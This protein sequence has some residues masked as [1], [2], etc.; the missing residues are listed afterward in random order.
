MKDFEKF[1]TDLPKPAVEV[2]VFRDRLRGELMSIAPGAAVRNWRPFALLAASAAV[3]LAVA[4][5][6]FVVQPA[7]PE[8][9]HAT[10][11]GAPAPEWNDDELQ[12]M[13][14]R[15]AM[16]AEDDRAFVDN[17]TAKQPRPV[18]V[19]SME[20]ERLFSVRQFELTD[21]KRMLVFTEL[22]KE[23]ARPAIQRAGSTAAAAVY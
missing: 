20:V 18:G 10:F 17:W 1:L 13:L 6:W 4:L 19:R 16:P 2:P 21:G 15:A 12:E 23:P 14:T 3:L 11:A 5:G 8:R 9:I 22:G 7:V